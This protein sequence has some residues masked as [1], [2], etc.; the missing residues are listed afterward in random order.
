MSNKSKYFEE[1]IRNNFR[2]IVLPFILIIILSDEVNHKDWQSCNCVINS[3]FII[4]TCM[5]NKSFL[6]FHK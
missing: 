5:Y 3:L 6:Y 1:D 4:L 2:L